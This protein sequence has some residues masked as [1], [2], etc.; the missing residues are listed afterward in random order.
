MPNLVCQ[1]KDEVVVI[2]NASHI[3]QNR[4]NKEIDESGEWKTYHSKG[5]LRLQKKKR[6]NRKSKNNA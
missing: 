2:P 3:P 6:Q 5:Y 4:Y 1:V